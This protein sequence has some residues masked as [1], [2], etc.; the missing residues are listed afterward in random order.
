MFK[1]H[2]AGVHDVAWRGAA[3]DGANQGCPTLFLH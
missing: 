3:A 1:K 2:K